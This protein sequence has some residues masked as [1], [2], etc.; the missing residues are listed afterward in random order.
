MDDK[1]HWAARDFQKPP[2][3]RIIAIGISQ[4]VLVYGN[5]NRSTPKCIVICLGEG[6]RALLLDPKGDVAH[7]WKLFVG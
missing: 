5:P 7:S 3:P 1:T 2:A 6:D 4:A